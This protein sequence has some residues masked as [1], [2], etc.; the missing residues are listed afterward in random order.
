MSSSLEL[1]I[2]ITLKPANDPALPSSPPH[3]PPDEQK[4]CELW[5]TCTNPQCFESGCKNALAQ[6]S[7]EVMS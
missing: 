7:T 3:S 4:Q 6:Q 2:H 1:S 5:V